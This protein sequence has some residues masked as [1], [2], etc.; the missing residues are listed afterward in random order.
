ML[1]SIAL[2]V[3]IKKVLL[4]I[5]A[6]A[7]YAL[8]APL[9]LGR[10]KNKIVILR[11]HSVGDHR[12]HEV[13]VKV[14]S[15]TKQMQLIKKLYKPT[16]LRQAIAYLR[17]KGDVP[18][19]S[20]VVTFDDGYRDNYEVAFAMLKGLGIL[21]T[22]FLTA[23]F[24]GTDNTL[25]HDFGDNPL[26]NYLLSWEQ[27]REMAKCGFDFGSHTLS[28]VNLGKDG[29]D[30]RK[31]LRESKSRIE[32][33]LGQEVLAV[34][35]PFGL[36]RDFSSNVKR[37]AREEGYACGFSAMNGVNDLATDIFALKR[38]GIEASD[39]MFT[40]RAKL[41]GALDLLSFKDTPVFYRLLKM[42]N[43]LLGV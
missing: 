12:R 11:Y 2:K 28:H 7:G 20:V 16:P 14:R 23:G 1:S 42:L 37:L 25:P 33:E 31:E 18:A 13:N 35:Y 19:K 9:W 21:P 8:L 41:N 34:S 15:F 3:F 26:Y 30:L 38:I 22:I 40:F 6:L 4:I 32:R 10:R 17:N 43:K 39:N 27:V 24:I 5:L 36:L 29:I